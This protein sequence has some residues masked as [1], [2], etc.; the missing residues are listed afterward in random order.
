MTQPLQTLLRHLRREAGPP[1]HGPL[2]DG[3]L[4]ERW[5]AHRDEAAFELLLRR[6]GPMVLASCR[7]QLG[8]RPEVEDA[9]QAT[10]LVFLLKAG[11]I[12]RRG[13]LAAW[14]DP[15]EPAVASLSRKEAAD[16]VAEARRRGH[17]LAILRLGGIDLEAGGR[18]EP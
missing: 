5:A 6:H 4:L 2:T 7:R 9:F 15:D 1:A 13:S 11:S 8:S 16:P 10:W 17:V 3:Q 12:R 18:P 14:R